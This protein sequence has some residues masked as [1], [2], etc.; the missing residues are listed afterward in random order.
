MRRVT[1]IKW[2]KGASIVE[3]YTTKSRLYTDLH[4]KWLGAS[5][6]LTVVHQK[7]EIVSAR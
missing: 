7:S 6:I 5:I 1:R 3:D 2:V 4:Q